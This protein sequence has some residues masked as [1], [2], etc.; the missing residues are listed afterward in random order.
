[1]CYPSQRRRRS[2]PRA[3]ASFVIAPLLAALLLPAG[4]SGRWI[5]D[6]EPFFP[7]GLVS[8]GYAVYPENWHA[9]IRESSANIVWDIE[10]AYADTAMGCEALIDSAAAGGYKLL[11]GSGDTWNW[12]DPSTPEFEV[13]QAL[14]EP[15]EL[16]HLLECANRIPGTV[17]SY[18]NRDEPGWTNSRN[19]IGDIDSTH[20]MWTY[21][22]LKVAAPDVPVS[23]NFAPAHL[24]GDIEQW[25]S[26]ITGYLPATDIVMFASYPYPYGPGTCGPRNVVGYP[27][28]KMD[29]LPIAADI[30]LTELNHPDQPLWMIV[31]AHKSIPYK[32]AK[33]EA[34]ASIVHGA[35]GIFWAGWDWW[36]PLGNG[37][38]SWPVTVDIMNE[39]AP[40]TPILAGFDVP[41][42]LT[43]IPDVE[44]RTLKGSGF[45]AATFAISRNGYAG[46]AR[47]RPPAV[48]EGVTQVVVR[49]EQR[50]LPIADGWIEDHFDAYEAH[51][52]RYAVQTSGTTGAAEVASSREPF[53]LRAFPNPS[54]GRTELEFRLPESASATFTVYDASGRRVALA[55]SGRFEAGSGTIAWSGRDFDGRPAA[56]GVYFIRATTSRGETATAKVLLQR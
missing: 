1:M 55:G 49:G 41:G 38:D 46:Y 31:Q 2:A 28:C 44:A 7:I 35:S 17:I 32:E 3:G 6:G 4:A 54:R 23:M 36:H 26:E 48:Q 37:I 42:T 10:I 33:W 45:Q 19:Q 14:Y 43:E 21:G 20:I 34:V 25:K 9:M 13:D 24:S 18:A 5:V 29:R 12:D 16:Q 40:M 27:E 51:V 53:A 39:L 52:Y 15:D 11:I 8:N 30:F 50:T 47:I 22:Q 56:P